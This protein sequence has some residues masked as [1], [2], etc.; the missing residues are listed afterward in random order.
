MYVILSSSTYPKPVTTTT[1]LSIPSDPKTPNPQTPTD[2]FVDGLAATFLSNY[3]HTIILHAVLIVFIVAV[4]L[5]PSASA[6]WATMY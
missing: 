2:T 3:L 1:Y 6:H 5:Y 4:Y